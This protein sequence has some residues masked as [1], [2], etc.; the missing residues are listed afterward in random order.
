M[1]KKDTRYSDTENTKMLNFFTDRVDPP[2]NWLCSVCFFL[3]YLNVNLA[4]DIDVL[5]DVHRAHSF[6]FVQGRLYPV[7]EEI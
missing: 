3:W 4:S 6:E 5:F 7:S 1:I 2:V